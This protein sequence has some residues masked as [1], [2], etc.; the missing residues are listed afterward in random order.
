M[1]FW[2]VWIERQAA[3]RRAL[4]RRMISE[5]EFQCLTDILIDKERRLIKIESRLEKKWLISGEKLDGN[6]L[7]IECFQ[8]EW[9]EK[10]KTTSSKID[11]LNRSR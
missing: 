7:R 10:F 9:Q 3:I 11:G 5:I 2:I 4:K 1:A 8:R 6:K